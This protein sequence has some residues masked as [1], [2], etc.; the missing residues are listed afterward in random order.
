MGRVVE[1]RKRR[2]E[3]KIKQDSRNSKKMSLS[4]VCP[5]EFLDKLKNFAFTRADRVGRE[6]TPLTG[7]CS[8]QRHF[9]GG[10]A[11]RFT[12]LPAN[13]VA[14]AQPIRDRA[15]SRKSALRVNGPSN[16]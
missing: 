1:K 8:L 15:L 4:R 16:G 9:F 3:L 5:G 7:H 2:T 14:Q 6:M 13:A 10:E 12:F 11:F